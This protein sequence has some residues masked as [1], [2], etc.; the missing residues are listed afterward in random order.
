ME[1]GEA[2]GEAGEE[3]GGG[4]ADGGRLEGGVGA[5]GE[6]RED[7]ARIGVAQGKVGE[8]AGVEGDGGRDGVEGGEAGGGELGPVIPVQERLLAQARE[9]GRRLKAKPSKISQGVAVEVWKERGG[10]GW[11]RPRGMAK[12]A[13]EVAMRRQRP[14][15][16]PSRP[17]ASTRAV[18]K[19]TRTSAPSRRSQVLPPSLRDRRSANAKVGVEG[20]VLEEE[21]GLRRSPEE[22]PPGASHLQ[23]PAPRLAL[24]L[25]QAPHT[26]VCT[27]HITYHIQ[28]S[29]NDSRAY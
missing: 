6:A 21:G 9:D 26:R 10:T 14:P 25:R 23:R 18:S 24:L 16:P 19:R 1:D 7:D 28:V 17:T 4:D 20:A 13:A 5:L 29:V 3:A 15:G 12:R 2:A 11:R 27:N 8:A 22:Q